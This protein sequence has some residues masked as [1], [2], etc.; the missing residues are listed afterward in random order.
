[1]INGSPPST[2]IREWFNLMQGAVQGWHPP[3]QLERETDIIST[4]NVVL[5]ALSVR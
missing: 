1:M 2:M 4:R 3:V 5:V